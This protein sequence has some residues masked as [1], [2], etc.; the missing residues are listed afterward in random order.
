MSNNYRKYLEEVKK[1]FPNSNEFRRYIEN[2]NNFKPL[3]FWEELLVSKELLPDYYAIKRKYLHDNNESLKGMLPRKLIHPILLGLMKMDRVLFNKQTLK[4]LINGEEASKEE[5]H[6]KMNN[7]KTI[8]DGKEKPVIYA[9]T[10]M[11]MYDYQVVSEVIKKHQVPFAGDPETLYRSGDGALLAANGLIY[12]D[13]EDEVDRKIAASTSVELLNKGHNL[14]I[15]PEGVWNISPN[16]LMLPLFPGIIKMAQE[17]GCDIVPIAIEQYDKDFIVNVGENFKVEKIDNEEYKQEYIEKKKNELRDT[18]ATLKWQI[19]EKLPTEER[20]NLGNYAKKHREF[21]DTRLNEWFN[22]EENKPY[23]NE[24]LVKH[25]TFR[26]KN[27]VLKED[28]FKY[29]DKIKLNKNNAF[30]FRK[31]TTYPVDTNEYFDEEMKMK[32]R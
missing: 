27:I 32:G 20:K 6:Q 24:D 12:C 4:V 26:I 31:D 23:Y 3:P 13:T 15:Y 19:F 7:I 1:E 25:R 29:L 28:V 10:H 5:W 17:T 11:G 14:L 21:V 2:I 22:K 18:M 8:G 30:M 9:I 16:L